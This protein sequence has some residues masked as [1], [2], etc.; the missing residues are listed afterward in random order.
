[1]FIM[2]ILWEKI[3]K[4][5]FYIIIISLI[6]VNVF[7]INVFSENIIK[8][9]KIEYIK[10]DSPF[11][12]N[13]PEFI[14]D[15]DNYLWS[16]LDS[17]RKTV[18]KA[19]DSDFAWF[20]IK[21]PENSEINALYYEGIINWMEIYDYTGNMIYSIIDLN[22][23]KKNYFKGFPSDII[24]IKDS[25]YGNYIYFRMQ[26]DRNDIGFI[27][28]IYMGDGNQLRK[29]SYLNLRPYIFIGAFL[30]IFGIIL[31]FS[32]IFS[33]RLQKG[34]VYLS[35]LMITVS[36]WILAHPNYAFINFTNANLYEIL[37]EYSIPLIVIF[38][39]GFYTMYFKRGFLKI[40]KFLFLLNIIYFIFVSSFDI[41]NTFLLKGD[42]LII[43]R[44]KGYYYIAFVIQAVFLI[45]D[46]LINALRKI[47]LSFF[48][49][50]G[51]T[52]LTLTGVYEVLADM[53]LVAWSKPVM[54]FG[55]LF[56]I[57][58]LVIII[59]KSFYNEKKSSEKISQELKDKNLLLEE[60]SEEKDM[61]ITKISHEINS[62]VSSILSMAK[63][64]SSD[65]LPEDR[66]NEI[67]NN[68]TSNSLK[69]RS[70]VDELLEFSR[71]RR[72]KINLSKDLFDIGVLAKFITSSL[73]PTVKNEKI[74][75][76]N[77]IPEN[78]FVY[79]DENR[80]YQVI[81][82][83]ISNSLKF[84]SSGYVKLS[85]AISDDKI[86]ICVSD[87]GIGI[88]GDKLDI[89]FKEFE[90]L[91]YSAEEGLGLGLSI[92]KHIMNLHGEKI[93][94]KSKINSGSEFF[95]T[96]EKNKPL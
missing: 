77:E 43:F 13:I 62:P 50:L 28:N 44:L 30:L 18:Y 6:F 32:G 41:I 66:Q 72:N 3:M 40:M 92:V 19:P 12:Q 82:N 4:K 35:F 49:F 75:I 73:I 8:V 55:F 60:L 90:Q 93:W 76:I 71:F 88:P 16:S 95:F 57:V 51:I 1:M 23:L 79:A 74:E 38:S 37:L 39:I 42:F 56:F 31:L 26:T 63:L 20:R 78:T 70:L 61:S 67:I 86:I 85:A 46:S 7:F 27:N 14:A 2:F 25:Y 83:L 64:L 33:F 34:I 94:V 10:G 36:F 52:V 53:R 80:I 29:F 24:E 65:K 81:N 47:D 17:E 96:L 68:I 21:I 48:Y 91:E 54:P 59:A 69:I 84:T 9:N 15:S 22:T 5:L 87:S 89:I 58:N 11:F 45:T